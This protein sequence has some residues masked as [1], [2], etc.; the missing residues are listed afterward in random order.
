MR[1]SWPLCIQKPSKATGIRL[2]SEARVSVLGVVLPVASM[3][4]RVNGHLWARPPDPLIP[5][6]LW[7]YHE[8]FLL[9]EANGQA[10]APSGSS[11]LPG[12]TVYT[13]WMSE[14]HWNTV[15]RTGRS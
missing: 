9:S 7:M 4:I 11:R 14:G 13:S 12:T 3:G 6:Q 10:L 8:P 5:Y 1:S 15:G 2:I